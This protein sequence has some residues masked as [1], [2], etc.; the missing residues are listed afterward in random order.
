LTI[1]LST[2]S[3]SWRP[4]VSRFFFDG[5]RRMERFALDLE[6]APLALFTDEEVRLA[7]LARV[8]HQPEPR[9]RVQEEQDVG[10]LQRVRDLDLRLRAEPEVLP[11]VDGRRFAIS[12]P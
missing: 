4:S 7:P 10:P 2:L 1:W 12:M 8:R 9:H 6:D 5:L 11:H 3:S